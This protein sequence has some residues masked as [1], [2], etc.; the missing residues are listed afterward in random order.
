[1]LATCLVHFKKFDG[2]VPAPPAVRALRGAGSFPRLKGRRGWF[3]SRRFVA[4]SQPRTPTTDPADTR[5]RAKMLLLVNQISE[6]TGRDCHGIPKRLENLPLTPGDKGAPAH[7][8]VG[9]SGT[10]AGR[11][12]P[13]PSVAQRGARGRFTEATYP[14]SIALDVMDEVFQSIG[15]TVK[16]AKGKKLTPERINELFEKWRDLPAK[17]KW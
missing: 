17:L 15:S 11:T 9:Q 4:E 16:A 14:A 3:N 2:P 13:E 1:M 10:G 8:P 7:L 12:G 5:R 6:L